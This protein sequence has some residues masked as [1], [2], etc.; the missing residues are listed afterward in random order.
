M[1]FQEFPKVK[2]K[3]GLLWNQFQFGFGGQIPFFHLRWVLKLSLGSGNL[4]KVSTRKYFMEK[5]N[6]PNW[7]PNKYGP[8]IEYYAIIAKSGLHLGQVA[9]N[10]G[11]NRDYY[12]R[13][14]S[15]QFQWISLPNMYVFGNKSGNLQ[16]TP[17]P[18]WDALTMNQYDSHI[19][20]DSAQRNSVY[21]VLTGHLPQSE[22]LWKSLMQIF[23]TNK[24]LRVSKPQKGMLQHFGSVFIFSI[25]TWVG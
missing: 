19:H 24:T 14:H 5:V 3:A 12:V 11:T 13:C 7:S 15:L 1:W 8:I 22:N 10:W 18:C 16:E 2:L 4:E 6:K 9:N 21:Y 23:Y 17:G 20:H 25:N